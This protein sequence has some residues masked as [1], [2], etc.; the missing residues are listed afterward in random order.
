MNQ[1]F[2][3][4]GAAAQP[5]VILLTFIRPDCP[6]CQQQEPILQQIEQAFGGAVAVERRNIYDD[7]QTAS[8]WGV[9][10]APTHYLCRPVP[11]NQPAQILSRQEGK[12]EYQQLASLLQQAMN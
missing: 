7:R 4:V 1:S 6:Y 5:R 11:A 12:L 2:P 9:K 10:A 8:S 3:T